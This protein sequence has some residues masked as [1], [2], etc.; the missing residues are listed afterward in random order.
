MNKKKIKAIVKK[1]QDE[2][3]NMFGEQGGDFDP[4]PEILNSTEA[5]IHYG[6]QKNYKYYTLA[7][8][9]TMHINIEN[10]TCVSGKIQKENAS[11]E[12]F[13][14]LNKHPNQQ[15]AM[16]IAIKVMNEL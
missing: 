3:E 7:Y 12:T 5:I 6:W 16:D 14:M 8:T 4:E 2:F 15:K 1:I 11:Q 13:A 10:K 9:S